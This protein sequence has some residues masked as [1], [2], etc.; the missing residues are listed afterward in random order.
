MK[1]NQFDTAKHGRPAHVFDDKHFIILVLN[2][3][4]SGCL[5]SKTW[6]LTAPLPQARC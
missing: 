2:C 4:T 5:Q 3:N 1:H 6:P